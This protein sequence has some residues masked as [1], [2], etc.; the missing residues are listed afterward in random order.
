MCRLQVALMLGAVLAALLSQVGC[1][2]QSVHDQLLTQYRTSE[3]QIVELRGQLEAA[4]THIQALESAPPP[5]DKAALTKLEAARQTV[6]K[7]Q[8]ALAA[9]ENTILKMAERPTPLPE[10]LNRELANLAATNPQLMSYDRKRGMVKFTSDLTFASGSDEAGREAAESLAQLA[11]ILNAPIAAKYEV[12]IVGHTD[13]VPIR[14]AAAKHP[15]NWHLSVH[16][17]IAVEKVLHKAGV[18]PVRIN[19]AGYGEHRPLVTNATNGNRANR[20]VEIFLVTSDY[21]P[22]DVNLV[23]KQPEDSAK[24]DPSSTHTDAEAG[25]TY[26]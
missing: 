5:R 6:K 19:V 16:R 7:L 14:Y 1:V 22:V 10:S 26:K 17:A 15:T 23:Q 9:A 4:Q 25:E 11:Q 8:N 2:S 21:H 20:R 12:R 13:N 24:A 3:E 18:A